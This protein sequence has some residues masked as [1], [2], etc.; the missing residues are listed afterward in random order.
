MT[1]QPE[2]DWRGLWLDNPLWPRVG[3]RW[4]I[5]WV[6]E[7]A[8]GQVVGALGNVPSLY[9]F[10]D[11]EL[12]CAN[13]RGW[14]VAAEY[15]GFALWLMDEYFNQSGADLF[16]NTTVNAIAAQVFSTLSA[17]VPL[18]DWQAAAYWITSYR[19]FARKVLAALGIPLAGALAPSAA[20]VLW[21]RDACLAKPL[22]T[23]A[24]DVVAADGF[25]A[26]FDGFWEEL[27]RQHPDKLLAVRDRQALAWHFAIPLRQ[28]RLWI[29]TAT[30]AGLVR[31]YC[32]LKRQDTPQGM[33]RMRLVDYQTL[34]PDNDLLGGLLQAALR[35]CAAE[36]F[37]LLEHLGG[38]LPKLA[39]FD[40]CAPY[41]RK[42]ANWMFYYQAADATLHPELCRP[43]VWDP[44]E[45]DGDA[46]FE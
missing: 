24:V 40:L 10:G 4:L 21:L 38:G 3:S 37:H 5:G 36:G 16:I 31:A 44:S 20:A 35:R 2:A 18:G 45:Y 33:R 27:L 8:S 25:D 7:D 28:G 46:S 41:H 42:L 6:L 30:R 12:L 19:G 23:A 29:L 14:V 34:E 17:R 26:R 43:E 32:I 22:P 15:R 11:R 39:N 9:H 13:G 1:T